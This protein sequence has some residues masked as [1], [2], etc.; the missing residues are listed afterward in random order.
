MPTSFT[1]LMI[2]ELL[3]I[4]SIVLLPALKQFG[5]SKSKSCCGMNFRPKTLKVGNTELDIDHMNFTIQKHGNMARMG[6]NP[7]VPLHEELGVTKQQLESL[8]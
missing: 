5:G 4:L 6:I 8:L 3:T 7:I 2:L 1:I